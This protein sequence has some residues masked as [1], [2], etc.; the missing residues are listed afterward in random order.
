ML[1]DELSVDVARSRWAF[2]IGRR[3]PRSAAFYRTR[4][5]LVARTRGQ[6]LQQVVWRLVLP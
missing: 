4:S 5:L 1:L 3:R 6:G 2:V